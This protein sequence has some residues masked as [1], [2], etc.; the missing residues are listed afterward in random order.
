V[1]VVK[2]EDYLSEQD[3]MLGDVSYNE[4]VLALQERKELLAAR[5]EL[6]EQQHDVTTRLYWLHKL[7]GRGTTGEKRNNG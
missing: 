7:A 2:S 5:S 4:L 6:E 3:I 1:G